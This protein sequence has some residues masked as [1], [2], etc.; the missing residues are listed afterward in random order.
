MV[1]MAH[2][3]TNIMCAIVAYNY[4]DLEWGAKYEG[5]SASGNAAFVLA[6]PYGIYIIFCYILA[7][8]F[9]RKARKMPDSDTTRS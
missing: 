6:I 1:V 3:F 9:W 5:W 8:A 4:C 7:Y 2:L